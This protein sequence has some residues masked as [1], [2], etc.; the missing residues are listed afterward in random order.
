MSDIERLA[1]DIYAV[2]AD[3]KSGDITPD[4]ADD[5]AVDLDDELQE[6]IS[7]ATRAL[8]E[9]DDL[10]AGYVNLELNRDNDRGW[11]VR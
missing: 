6:L 7:P 9:L 10:I 3:L 4:Q 8:A 11:Y 2:V 5:R 1:E